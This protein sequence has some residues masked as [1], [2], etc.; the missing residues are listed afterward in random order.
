MKMTTY[1]TEYTYMNKFGNNSDNVDR[2]TD[3]LGMPFFDVSKE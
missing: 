3:S 2:Q 1:D